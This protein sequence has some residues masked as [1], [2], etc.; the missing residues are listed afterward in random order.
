MN[1]STETKDPITVQVVDWFSE[2]VVVDSCDNDS[3]DDSHSKY[4][5]KEY[6]I[7]IFGRDRNKKSVA[8][9]VK[10]FKPFFYVEIPEEWTSGHV[11]NF[12]DAIKLKMGKISEQGFA[13]PPKYI[14]RKKFRGF[15]NDKEFSFILFTFNNR[16]TM[17]VCK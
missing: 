11:Y 2:D 14:R 16:L 13:A 10:H 12:V 15:Q 8:I 7:T 9:T 4:K 17:N 1:M 5:P 3:D 6:E